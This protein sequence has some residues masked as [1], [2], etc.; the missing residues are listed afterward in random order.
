MKKNNSV[1]LP[2]DTGPTQKEDINL[3][4]WQFIKKEST[5]DRRQLLEWTS[6]NIGHWTVDVAP[7]F[8][9]DS[10]E[11]YKFDNKTFQ[12][13]ISSTDIEDNGVY[14]CRTIVVDNE[15]ETSLFEDSHDLIVQ[16]TCLIILFKVWFSLKVLLWDGTCV[17]I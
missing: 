10:R 1:Q 17:C 4:R 14:I 6:P 16:G 13:D 15:T 5:E 9:V 11:H 3:V 7:T 8:S 12:L 2:C